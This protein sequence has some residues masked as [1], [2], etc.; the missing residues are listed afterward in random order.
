MFGANMAMTAAATSTQPAITSHGARSPRARCCRTWLPPLTL[1]FD[2]RHMPY[3]VM[4]LMA[5][6]ALWRALTSGIA[7]HKSL[8]RDQF[9][10]AGASERR[11][12][13][14]DVRAVTIDQAPTRRERKKLETRQAL[15]QAALRLFGERG[16]EQTTVEDIAE[17]ADVA[18]RTF[19]RYFSSKQDVLFGEVVTDRVTRLRVELAARPAARIRSLGPGGHGPARLQR[20]RR[21]GA[22][23]S[24]AWSSCAG[25]R[26]SSPGTWRSW[27]RCGPWWS[28][29]WPSAPGSTPDA[30]LYPLLV[31]GACAVA[32]DSSLKLWVESGG[33]ALAAR[34]A[35]RGVH[36]AHQRP[37]RQGSADDLHSG[38]SRRGAVRARHQLPQ[39][40][41]CGPDPG[42]GRPR[43]RRPRDLDRARLRQGKTDPPGRHRARRPVRPARPA[44]RR[45][46]A[47]AR[48]HSRRGGLGP[49]QGPAASAS[50]A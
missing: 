29:S 15:E 30:D 17:A 35:Y 5:H 28:S 8:S 50:T 42:V 49:G 7:C 1:V 14:H 12:L 47:R 25:S 2:W 39:G 24:P 44:D 32:W 11:D 23:S 16:Y 38:H 43:R 27:T 37:T 46:G 34:A 36:C 18:V 3:G 45:P 22:R 40:R 19:F 6:S 33:T 20:A 13:C 26:R 10:R 48:H 9:G 4:C 21:G 41:P 31:G